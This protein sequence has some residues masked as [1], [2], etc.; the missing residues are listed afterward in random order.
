MVFNIVINMKALVIRSLLLIT[1]SAACPKRDIETVLGGSQSSAIIVLSMTFDVE[2]NSLDMVV[3]ATIEIEE[4][5]SAFIYFIQEATCS[6]KWSFHDRALE[7]GVQS[8][9][10]DPSLPTRIYGVMAANSSTGPS[11]VFWIDNSAP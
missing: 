8:V 7:K 1:V 6:V 5:E 4:L 2:P 10:F 9:A 3:G 11:Y